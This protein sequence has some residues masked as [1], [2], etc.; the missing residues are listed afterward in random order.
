MR[1]RE[2]ARADDFDCDVVPSARARPIRPKRRTHSGRRQRRRRNNINDKPPETYSHTHTS[3][4]FIFS[5]HVSLKKYII[6]CIIVAYR[7]ARICHARRLLY[8]FC[9][10]T[11]PPESAAVY[12]HLYHPYYRY[13][14]HYYHYYIYIYQAR[15]AA[16]VCLYN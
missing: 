15:S 11:P 9:H 8:I 13:Y 3:V 10:D 2:R 16:A 14:Y 4:F 5:I 6:L 1:D 7:P 12:Y